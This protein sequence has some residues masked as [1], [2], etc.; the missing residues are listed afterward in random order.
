M[1]I[2]FA[3]VADHARLLH[4][5]QTAPIVFAAGG[6][7]DI[8]RMVRAGTVSLGEEHGRLWGMAAGTT[9]ARPDTL[10][11]DAADR[12]FVRHLALVRGRSP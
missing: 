12:A 6:Q 5:A 9:E 11:T 2:R 1:S 3:T 8:E 10:P 7:E 4:L